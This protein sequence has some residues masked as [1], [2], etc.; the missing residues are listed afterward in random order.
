[1]QFGVNPDR[2]IFANPTKSPSHIKFARKVG[3][4]KMTADSEIELMKIKDLFPEAKYVTMN[5]K[6][7]NNNE[8]NNYSISL[9]SF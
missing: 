8:Y 1:M 6:I 2:I 4:E 3:V 5:K 9:F 7:Y